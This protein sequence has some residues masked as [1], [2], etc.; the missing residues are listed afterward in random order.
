MGGLEASVLHLLVDSLCLDLKAEK[1]PGS[2]LE[3]QHIETAG[4]LPRR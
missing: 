2:G 4:Y 3:V 1:V